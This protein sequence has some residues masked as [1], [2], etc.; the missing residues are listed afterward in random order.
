MYF[1]TLNISKKLTKEMEV[2]IYRIIQELL[3][4]TIK[5]SQ[6]NSIIVQCSENNNTI[7]IT[8][9]DDGIGFNPNQ[10]N[11]TGLGL[12][13]KKNGYSIYKAKLKL[14]LQKIMEQLLIL[15]L[16]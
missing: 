4:N 8:V 11:P 3:T 5:D 1:Q 15:S 9:E 14:F 7:Y 12:N 6:A 10:Y 13:N 2:T 16:I